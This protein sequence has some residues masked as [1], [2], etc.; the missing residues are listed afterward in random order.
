MA[1]VDNELL[2][3]ACEAGRKAY[4]PYSKYTVGVAARTESG[5]TIVGC[6]V[7]NSSY[8]LTLCAECALV[9]NLYL[10]EAGKITEFVCVNADSEVITPCGRCRQLLFE[11]SIR[12]VTKIWVKA[13]VCIMPDDL[14]PYAWDALIN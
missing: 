10:Q 8:G 2:Q 1:T 7:E 13:D 6:N 12:G 14:V 11:H 4:V 9:S 5:K 3:A